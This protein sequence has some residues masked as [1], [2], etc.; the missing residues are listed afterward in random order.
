MKLFK[1]KGFVQYAKLGCGFALFLLSFILLIIDKSRIAGKISYPDDT[2]LAFVFLLLGSFCGIA[3]FFFDFGLDILAPILSSL[4]F[5]KIV[6]M[7]C[8]PITDLVTGVG[9]FSNSLA[10][11]KELSVI[12][13]VLVVF[14]FLSILLSIVVSFRKTKKKEAP[15]TVKE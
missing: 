10:F 6:V 5:G 11:A 2:M 12:Y 7:A 8:Y 13:I 15:S 3:S 4:G 9:F 14:S 1:N